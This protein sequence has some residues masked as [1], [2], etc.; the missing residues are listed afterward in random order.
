MFHVDICIIEVNPGKRVAILKGQIVCLDP[1]DRLALGQFL[2]RRIEVPWG[3]LGESDARD[4]DQRGN[5]KDSGFAH[6]HPPELKVY[7]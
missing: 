3:L 4:Q 5:H 2:N 6:E 1:Y 7:T